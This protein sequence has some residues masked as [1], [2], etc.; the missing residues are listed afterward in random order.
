MQIKCPLQDRLEGC[1]Y[2]PQLPTR[3]ICEWDQCNY[4]FLSADLFYEHV[5]HHAHRLLDK[6]Y[7]AN[8]NKVFT[9]IT[10][11][12]FKDHLRVHTLQKLYACPHCGYFFSTRIKFDD[13]F[14]RQLNLTDL[15]KGRPMV[16]PE[17]TTPGPRGQEAVIEEYDVGSVTGRVR[18]FR[19]THNNCDKRFL[20][21]TLLSE[22][23]RAIHSSRYQCD[24]CQ[25]IAKSASQLDS[26]KLYRHQN[27]R[28]FKCNICSMAFKQRGDL[29]AHVKRHQIV[30]PYRCNK[31]EFETPN[32]DCLT[33]HSKVHSR[34]YDYCCHICRRV[35]SR[36]N[37]LSRHL[38][39]VHKLELPNGCSRFKYKLCQFGFYVI[40]M[41]D[42]AST[43][44]IF[45]EADQTEQNE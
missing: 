30:E 21:S 43:L 20:T 23:I 19:C 35:F 3:L 27:I 41:G 34:Q 13:H 38:K 9:K 16:T 40:D 2:F 15:L 37:N 5:S 28:S 18:V 7:W 11:T 44:A 22:H 10:S 31:C 39:D 24:N 26:H 45:L 17:T 36:G 42:D 1:Y 8:C 32:E 6:C 25:F 12:L 4:E 29:R 14:L 33:K